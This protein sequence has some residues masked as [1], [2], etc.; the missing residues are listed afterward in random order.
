MLQKASTLTCN[1]IELKGR[2]GHA[3]RAM[4]GSMFVGRFL[5]D[6]TGLSADTS[7]TI[8]VEK[9]RGEVIGPVVAR[10]CGMIALPDRN[11]IGH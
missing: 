2:F 9:M 11:V 4:S 1:D 6:I 7:A 10:R 8:N 3:I 5:T